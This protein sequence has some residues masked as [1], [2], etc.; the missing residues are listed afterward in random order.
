MSFYTGAE[1]PIST[2]KTS[3]L[4]LRAG[5][6]ALKNRRIIFLLKAIEP[7]SPGIPVRTLVTIPTELP[8]IN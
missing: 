2:G 1:S 5:L 8:I 7:R 4:G 6:D 3:L